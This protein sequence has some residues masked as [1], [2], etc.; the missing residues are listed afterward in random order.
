MPR[1]PLALAAVFLLS[2]CATVYENHI[3]SKLV[4]AG[5]E[6]PVAACIADRMVDRL[7]RR[8][9]NSL[10]RLASGSRR[11]VADMSLAQFLHHYRAALDPKVYRVLAGAGI[12]CALAG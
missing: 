11:R 8:Q 9:L 2:S 7:S 12:R 5:L 3:E 6:P 4:H 10:G 1:L